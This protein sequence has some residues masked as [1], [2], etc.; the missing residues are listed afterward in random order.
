MGG[1]VAE[2]CSR[3]ATRVPEPPQ[4][5]GEEKEARAHDNDGWRDIPY[6]IGCPAVVDVRRVTI[7]GEVLAF[8]VKHL[9]HV[10]RG[11]AVVPS[12]LGADGQDGLALLAAGK[13]HQYGGD[14][15]GK[16]FQAREAALEDLLGEVL[17]VALDLVNVLRAPVGVL[18]ENA[19]EIHVQR[20]RVAVAKI[21][22]QKLSDS[23][24]RHVL[25]G[26]EINALRPP[27]FMMSN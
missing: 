9:R 10:L 7:E 25:R 15:T 1:I 17:A 3:V 22:S 23:I 18:H 19:M 11:V 21:G 24:T 26:Y 14:V 5:V 2:P 20:Q 13:K 16:G 4:I 27:L 8:H 12:V 6:L